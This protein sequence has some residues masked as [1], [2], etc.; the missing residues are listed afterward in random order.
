MNS[1]SRGYNEYC[2]KD[3]R[4]E[5]KEHCP[6]IIK[7]GCPSAVTIPGLATAGTTFTIASLTLDTS[8]LCDP[9]TKLEFASNIV[10][11]VGFT[12][13]AFTIQVFKQCRCQSAPV[14]VGPVWSYIPAIPG[15]AETFS[16][17]ICD[18]DSCFNDC[19]TYTAVATVTTTIG[20]IGLSINNSTLGAI[21]TCK[22][23]A[24][25]TNCNRR[26]CHCECDC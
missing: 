22:S 8:C 2:G 21:S 5:E 6:T 18:S 24:C 16:F 23:N 11:P 20:A 1:M 14:P 4:K 17:F 12:D 15:S 3:K 25:A 19:C 13:G 10:V 26:K 9:S 7:C